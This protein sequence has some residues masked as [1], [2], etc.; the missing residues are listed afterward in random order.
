MVPPLV[1]QLKLL[2]SEGVHTYD[3]YLQTTVLI[4]APVICILCDNPRASEVT[5][6]L[7]TSAKLFCRICMVGKPL[8]KCAVCQERE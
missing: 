5:N 4:V 3:A 6:N 2:E 1:E 8:M 7:G